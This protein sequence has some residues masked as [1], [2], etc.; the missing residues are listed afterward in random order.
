MLYTAKWSVRP[1]TAPPHVRRVA[2]KDELLARSPWG[3]TTC[4]V[5]HMWV[6]RSIV[7][8]AI[9]FDTV[10]DTARLQVGREVGRQV[11][12]K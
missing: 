2:A 7:G 12:R 6:T 5:S 11:G 10:K 4:L 3:S 1:R 9:G 8:E